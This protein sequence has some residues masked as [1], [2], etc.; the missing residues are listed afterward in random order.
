MFPGGSWYPD[1]DE[2]VL[3]V[4]KFD[5]A[6]PS[7]SY[8]TDPYK[9]YR[10]LLRD[11]L[12]GW[13]S[14]NVFIVTKVVVHIWFWQVFDLPQLSLHFWAK[15]NGWISPKTLP[16]S[17]KLPKWI[18]SK[19]HEYDTSH[20]KY[21]HFICVETWAWMRYGAI[22]QFSMDNW[23]AVDCRAWNGRLYH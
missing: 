22:G 9:L 12:V 20:I 21:G 13:V 18:L 23:F 8:S 6:L 16:K 17:K 14:Q 3:L 10:I 5:C 11:P 2:P 7:R 4:T 19:C 15:T 1:P